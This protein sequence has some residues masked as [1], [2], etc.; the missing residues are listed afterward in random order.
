VNWKKWGRNHFHTELACKFGKQLHCML[1]N[2]LTLWL[3]SGSF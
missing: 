1:H 2:D 3:S